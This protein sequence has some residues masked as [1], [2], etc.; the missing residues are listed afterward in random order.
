MEKPSEMYTTEYRH[1]DTMIW[2]LPT[3]C[4]AIFAA[5]AIGV[6][7]IYSGS[8]TEATGLSKRAVATGF[9]VSMFLF[10]LALSHAL[11]HFRKHQ[12][13]FRRFPRVPFWSSA[14]TYLQMVVTLEAFTLLL[15]VL[16]IN[17]LR[18]SSALWGCMLIALLITLYREFVLRRKKS[19]PEQV[20]GSDG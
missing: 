11:Y 20:S 2:Q 1:F 3:W 12:A 19:V 16:L 5:T 9:L 17:G 6:N 10:I 18:P 13:V 4:T 7:S 8:I 14:Q 15:L